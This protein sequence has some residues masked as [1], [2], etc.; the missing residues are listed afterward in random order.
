MGA[1]GISLLF[2]CI[3]LLNNGVGA[4]KKTDAKTLSFL[5]IVTGFVIIA[6][7]LISLSKADTTMAYL[8]VASGF[9]FGFT[10]LFVAA[11][12]LFKLDGSAFGW[13][14]LVVA[15]FATIQGVIA[16]ADGIVWMGLLWI[17]WALLWLEGFL[18]LSCKVKRLG[19]VYPW[20]AIFEAVFAAGIPAVLMLL[21]VWPM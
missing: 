18:E 8:N 21:E 9:L 4:L 5:N 20:L 14:S 7:N 19:K 13:F 1:L 12:M 15:V 2:V 10:Y 11:N 3:A 16:L 6:V 17:M